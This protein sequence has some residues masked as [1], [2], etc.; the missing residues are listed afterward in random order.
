MLSD[1][2]HIIYTALNLRNKAFGSALDFV[3]SVEKDEYAV[4]ETTSKIKLYKN[5]KERTSFKPVRLM[6]C[7]FHR[8]TRRQRTVCSVSV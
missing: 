4:R 5:F 1:G 6:P 8:L 7:P 2:E 3:W